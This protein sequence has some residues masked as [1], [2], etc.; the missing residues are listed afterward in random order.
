MIKILIAI[1]ILIIHFDVPIFQSK[2]DREYIVEKMNRLR[3]NGCQCGSIY[4]DSVGPVE[5]NTILEKTA[6]Q[7]ARQMESYDF[8]SHKSQEGMDIGQR[9]DEAGYNWMYA[10]ENLAE[11]QKSFDEA[12][13]DWL[14]SPTHCRM[15]MNPRMK[16][17][18]LS[19]FGKYWVQHFGTKMPPKTV[20]KSVHYR[21]G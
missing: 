14:E 15:L 3:L 1:S 6:Y 4:M 12:F 11:G 20:R 9:L 10:G 21:E 13:T 5:W 18:G 7:H 2:I 17:M 8:F 19:K 16:E